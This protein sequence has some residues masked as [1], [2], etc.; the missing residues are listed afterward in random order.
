VVILAS[1]DTKIKGSRKMN[2]RLSVGQIAMEP[3]DKT[4]GKYK[5]T[6]LMKI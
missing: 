2:R 3:I 6:Q 5:V 4:K 1:E